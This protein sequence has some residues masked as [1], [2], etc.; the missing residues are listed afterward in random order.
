MAIYHLE[1][2]PITRSEGH[3]AVKAAA[4]RSGEKLHDQ[5][6]DKTFDYS[7]RHGVLYAEIVT[8]ENAPGWMK[9]GDDRERLWNEVE[10]ADKR[11]DAQ[12]AKE[13][14][15]ALPRELTIEE[16]SK[17]VHGWVT[18]NFAKQG[19]VADFSIHES[20][21]LD[22][23]KN[24]HAHIMVATR[25]VN[26]NGFGKKWRD[27]DKKETLRDLRASWATATNEALEA[28]GHK[29]RVDHRTLDAQGIDRQPTNHIGKDAAAMERQGKSTRKGE[30]KRGIEFE[31]DLLP[32]Q[33][34]IE[35]SEEPWAFQ[36]PA[37]VSGWHDKYAEWQMRRGVAHAQ[38]DATHRQHV[39]TP[40]PKSSRVEIAVHDAR[41]GAIHTWRQK[42]ETRE[43]RRQEKT[44]EQER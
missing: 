29:G 7:R 36:P 3:Q 37:T 10:K 39:S 16:N 5:R 41:E 9:P 23:E 27:I 13:Y 43:T 31:N 1:A 19:L 12:L 15:V 40:T 42:E 35:Q 25:L 11:K 18:D 30:Q 2:K 6:S 33:R 4:Y 20:D 34:V 24:P 21:A 14:I 17:L 28:G 32:Y 22:G 8:P 44:S 38:R 26:E